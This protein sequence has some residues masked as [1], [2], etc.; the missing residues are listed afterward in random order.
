MKK[1]CIII[2]GPT[3]VGKTA[4][5]VQVA[6]HFSTSII[7]ADSRQCYQE[8]NIGVAKPSFQELQA[9]H[10]YFI[11]SHSIHQSVNAA[12]FERYALAAV[13][14]IFSVAD[15]AVIVGGTGLYIKAFQEGLDQIP[16][17]PNEFRN[18]LIAQYKQLGLD[19]L[20]QQIQSSD[21]EFFT[22]GEIH[23]PQ[24]MLRA[25]EVRLFTGKSI[26]SFQ[27]NKAVNRDFDCINI[28]VELPRADLYSRINIRVDDMI[29]Q[30]LVNEVAQLAPFRHLNALQTVGYKELF[31]YV[32][33]SVTLDFAIEK[34]KQNTRHYAKRQ[35]TWLKNQ[36]HHSQWLPPDAPKV[37]AHIASML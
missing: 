6:Q 25:L 22:T 21:P 31:E 18:N 26:R 16:P 29:E 15:V 23:N 35:I 32:D 4:L 36:F 27:N 17:V 14:E 28:A 37:I 5:A 34:I 2:S 12:D 8:L 30:G 9:V 1:K 10:H 7:S 33:Q 3:A 24:R 11:N 19:W 20:A 13:Q